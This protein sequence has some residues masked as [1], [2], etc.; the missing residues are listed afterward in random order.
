MSNFASK[1]L[2][3][4]NE[5][6]LKN[7]QVKESYLIIDYWAFTADYDIPKSLQKIII[8]YVGKC[9]AHWLWTA[10]QKIGISKQKKYIHQRIMIVMTTLPIFELCKECHKNIKEI[11]ISPIF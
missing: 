10:T 1:F 7:P 4:D 9:H 5:L 11:S 3:I 8:E 6:A 2:T